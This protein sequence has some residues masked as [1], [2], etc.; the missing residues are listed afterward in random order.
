MRS[1]SGGRDRVEQVG[2][3]DEEHLGEVERHLQVVVL[4]GVVLLRVEHL[5]QRR[6]RVAAEVHA[7][8]VDLVEHEDRV[9]RAAGLDVLDD[10]AGQRAD[11][12]A[13]VTADLGLVVDAAEAHAHEL[14]AHGPGDDLPSEVLPTPGG[15]TKARMGLRSVSAR[16]RTARYSRMRS[17]IFSRP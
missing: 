1:R 4:E 14:A 2:G 13:P 7:D 12:G 5:E 15:P 3:G 17:L 16:L 6:A 8:L 11:V 10:P 9:V